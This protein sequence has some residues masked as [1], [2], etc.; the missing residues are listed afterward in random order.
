V[1]LTID[2][3][4]LADAAGVAVRA[5]PARPPVPVLAA[6]KL[7]AADGQLAV[8]GYDYEISAHAAA[9]ARITEPGTV[10]VPGRLFTEIARALRKEVHVATDGTRLTLESGN[11]R[12]TLHTLP[13]GEYPTLPEL[14]DAT[15]TLAGQV[16]AE[17]V[18]QVAIAAA[19]DTAVP[20]LTGVQLEVE[21]PTITLAATDRYR[22]AVRTLRWEPDGA[23]WNGRALLPAKALLDTAKALAADAAVYLT[24]ADEDSGTNGVTGLTGDTQRTT[25]RGLE[26][27]LPSYDALFPTEFAAEAVVPTEALADMVKRVALV[28]ERNTP[29]RLAFTPGTVTI[30]AGSSDDAQAVDR[31]DADYTDHTGAEFDTFRIAFN[32][33]FLLDG[34]TALDC[35]AVRIRFTAPHKPA[36]LTADGAPDTGLKY[37]LMPVR[38][39]G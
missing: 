34:L 2:A 15:G 23:D 6:L 31:A 22:F 25:M 1:K 9:A 32:P 13:L 21:G 26:G 39:S 30:E 28:A 24:L 3:R 18:A 14:P 4:A 38:L 33:Q 5:L 10:L 19:R 17:A 16:L 36:L 29:V 12:F 20:V 37:L 7:Q 8:T 11:S 35:D 27:K